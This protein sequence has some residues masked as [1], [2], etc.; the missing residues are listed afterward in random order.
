MISIGREAFAVCTALTSVTIG[1]SV[2]L[3]EADAFWGCAS[4]HSITSLNP[5]PP[6]VSLSGFSGVDFDKC[7]LSVPAEALALYQTA[8]VWRNF[9]NIQAIEPSNI[10]VVN[11]A[12]TEIQIFPNPVVREL[13]IINHEWKTG[14]VVELYDINGKLVFS[15]GVGA[16][17]YSPLQGNEFTIDMSPFNSGNYI[18]QIGN[19]V[20]KVVKL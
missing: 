17:N 11:V 9:L 20:A 1:S 18:L 14:D 10:D 13:R 12:E 15:E 8:N 16:S 3:I 2:V 4:L 19:H 6:E 5:V 7:R